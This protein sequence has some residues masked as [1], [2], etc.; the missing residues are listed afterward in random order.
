MQSYDPLPPKR[1]FSDNADI[2]YHPLPPVC[3]N[4][5]IYTPHVRKHHK[6]SVSGDDIVVLEKCVEL[7][8]A[9]PTDLPK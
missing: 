6:C 3:D 1:F 7:Y 2:F 9:P 4:K 8:A 5:G